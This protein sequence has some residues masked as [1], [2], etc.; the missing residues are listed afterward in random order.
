MKYLDIMHGDKLLRYVYDRKTLK[1]IYYMDVV[2]NT[3]PKLLGNVYDTQ[4]KTA[5]NYLL[6][7]IQA[8][9]TM[10]KS[11]VYVVNTTKN[12]FSFYPL[13][14]EPLLE[15]K[16]PLCFIKEGNVYNITDYLHSRTLIT[17]LAED[18]NKPIQ[19]MDWNII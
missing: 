2:D 9:K 17:D 19:E 16:F 7:A 6:L 12:N 11:C 8:R 5:I 3:A 14:V 4:S 15:K 13:D 18:E 10:K 1:D